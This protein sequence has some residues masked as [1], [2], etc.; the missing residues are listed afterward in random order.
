MKA[1]ENVL[2]ILNRYAKAGNLSIVDEES[3]ND[4]PGYTPG[5]VGVY[6]DY[7][8]HLL[9]AGD[10]DAFS[11]WYLDEL[12]KQLDRVMKALGYRL[13]HENDGSGNGLWYCLMVY[14]KA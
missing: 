7:D 4:I 8:D 9:A 3:F 10:V 6:A 2:N 5:D 12:P 11:S 14:R 13:V 1:L